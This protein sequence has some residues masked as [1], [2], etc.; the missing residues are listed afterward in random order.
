MPELQENLE[1]LEVRINMDERY[2]SGEP[3]LGRLTRM[4]DS[5]EREAYIHGTFRDLITYVL[6]DSTGLNEEQQNTY[7]VV[8]E[9][10][11]NESPDRKVLVKLYDEDD[12]E[13]EGQFAPGDVYLDDVVSDKAGDGPV[14]LNMGV[15]TRPSVG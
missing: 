4:I 7:A 10:M 6:K 2:Q 5:A 11:D 12:E 15:S 1:N 14:L 9:R 13:I 3:Q 8:K